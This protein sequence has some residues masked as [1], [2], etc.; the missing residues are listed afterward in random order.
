MIA[1]S[2][3]DG[4]LFTVAAPAKIILYLYRSQRRHH[5]APWF[6][7]YHVGPFGAKEVARSSKLWALATWNDGLA[8]NV[9]I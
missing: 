4:A 8:D 7:V 2:P 1:H 6:G 9:Q 5:V 3:A